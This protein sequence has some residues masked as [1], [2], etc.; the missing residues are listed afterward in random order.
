M[1]YLQKHLENY[2][3]LLNNEDTKKRRAEN[4]G[5][6]FDGFE[7]GTLKTQKVVLVAEDNMLDLLETDEE[8]A[9]YNMRKRMRNTP[10]FCT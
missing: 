4:F 5:W 3:Q 9:L 2:N 6:A 10:L 8:V 7:A 1:Y